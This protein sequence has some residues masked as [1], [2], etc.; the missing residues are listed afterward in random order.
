MRMTTR[1]D[2]AFRALMVC[3]VNAGR[4]VRKQDIAERCGASEHHVA[5]IVHALGRL[6]LLAT[7][8]GRTGGLTLARPAEAIRLGDV[9][10]AFDS[11]LPFAE[12]FEGATS[13]CPLAASCR[14]R[15]ALAAAIG[16][17]HAALDRLTVADL[18][19][20]NAPLERLLEMAPRGRPACS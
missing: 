18:V 1:T 11:D 12:C 4:T 2:L 13:R 19:G 20:C 10:R 16:A 14:M 7:R 8:R 5:Q 17:F 3:A 15:D 6:G 9:F